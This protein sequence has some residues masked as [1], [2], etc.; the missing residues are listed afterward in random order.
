M[1]ENDAQVNAG[2][3]AMNELE[4]L[5]SSIA[6]YFNGQSESSSL[7]KDESLILSSLNVFFD[8]NYRKKQ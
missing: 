3:R 8:G 6:K 5:K 2:L 1:G 7:K 4:A